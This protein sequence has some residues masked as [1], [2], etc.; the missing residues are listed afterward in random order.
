[1]AWPMF[2]DQWAA[3]RRTGTQAHSEAT[4]HDIAQCWI[5]NY[6]IAF[7]A[8]SIYQM[9]LVILPMLGKFPA[10]QTPSHTDIKL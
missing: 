9:N 6:S 10:I 3:G 1:M 7:D 8:N 4:R 2:Y 5:K